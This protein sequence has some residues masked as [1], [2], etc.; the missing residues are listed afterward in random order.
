[1]SPAKRR[2][3]GLIPNA[4]F[5]G[6]AVCYAVDFHRLNHCDIGDT[7]AVTICFLG[8]FNSYFLMSLVFFNIWWFGKGS[9]VLLILTI[10]TFAIN[11]LFWATVILKGLNAT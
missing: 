4:V 8:V 11:A 1:M 6:L 10:S 5:I 9:R 2:W 3:M 7:I